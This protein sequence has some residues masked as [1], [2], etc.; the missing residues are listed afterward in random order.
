[1]AVEQA[2]PE[3]SDGILTRIATRTENLSEQAYAY[4]LLVPAFLVLLLFA[5]WPLASAIRMS[6][7]ADVITGMS[8]SASRLAAVSSGVTTA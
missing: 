4:L 7:F 5:F 2:G 8:R 1:M 3:V 6:F